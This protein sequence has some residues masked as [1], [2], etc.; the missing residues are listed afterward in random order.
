M[1]VPAQVTRR[2]C[3][4]SKRGCVT[5]SKECLAMFSRNSKE[6]F[7]LFVTVNETSIHHTR[8]Q[9]T[10]NTVGFSAWTCTKWSWSHFFRDACG[11]ITINYLEKG[12]IITF[13][14]YSI[15]IWRINNP[16]HLA[17]KCA[18]PSRR[19]TCAHMYSYQTF[20]NWATNYYPVQHILQI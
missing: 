4:S 16:P 13:W 11:V 9:R 8:D 1:V 6:F 3:R 10:I 12:K 7:R 17:K 2:T 18:V 5:T 14:T 19:C 15:L 20:L